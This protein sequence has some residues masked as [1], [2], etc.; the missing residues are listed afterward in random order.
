MT[1]LMKSHRDPDPGHGLCLR[2]HLLRIAGVV[3]RLT[4]LP[5]C[6][7][8]LLG[9]VQ[10]PILL[11]WCRRFLNASSASFN[12]PV[13]SATDIVDTSSNVLITIVICLK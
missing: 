6:V 5:P 9:E 3:L 7:P 4:L 8:L 11:Q 10:L 2:H 1:R 13:R 12:R